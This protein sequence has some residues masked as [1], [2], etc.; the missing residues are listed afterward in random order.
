MRRGRNKR[1]RRRKVLEEITRR[2]KDRRY[3]TPTTPKTTT[4]ATERERE[5]ERERAK[6]RS[7]RSAPTQ[8]YQCHRRCHPHSTQGKPPT[9][10]G[11]T[12]PLPRAASAVLGVPDKRARQ[13]CT[14]ASFP[15]FHDDG[16]FQSP[17]AWLA[18]TWKR[19]GDEAPSPHTRY[20]F[21]SVMR[22]M[23]R[24]QCG[25]RPRFVHQPP[26]G[27]VRIIDRPSTRKAN[28]A[29]SRYCYVTPRPER[30]GK[31][32]TDREKPG[33]KPTTSAFQST[34]VAACQLAQ[35]HHSH[36]PWKSVH[37]EVGSE[38]WRAIQ[39]ARGDPP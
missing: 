35:D 31:R 36:I 27:F 16:N 10:V 18:S 22:L 5:R 24:M 23:Q 39:R 33:A 21:E 20:S 7:K 38:R 30:C 4:T 28:K 19:G 2:E 1:K 3:D 13:P 34:P 25:Q 6:N 14:R 32:P 15:A 9:A 11:R 29:S 26:V 8:P 37:R 12:V 17:E